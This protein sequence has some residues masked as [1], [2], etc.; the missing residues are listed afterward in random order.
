MNIVNVARRSMSSITFS[1][2]DFHASDPD[3]DD[4]MVVTVVISQ[5][6][7][8]KALID[9]GR[10]V[11]ILYWKMFQKMNLLEDV[12]VL[13]NEKIVGFAGERVDTQ[14]YVD[15]RTS[16]GMERGGRR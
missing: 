13:Y 14:G 7:V 11:N 5:Y 9:Q 15:L 6:D 16:F 1:D 10:L 12:I 3:Q 2:K 8:S 4:P